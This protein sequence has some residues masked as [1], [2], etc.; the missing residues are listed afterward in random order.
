MLFDARIQTNNI[1]RVGDLVDDDYDEADMEI[2]LMNKVGY[3]FFSKN[4]YD[5]N[6][7]LAISLM[8]DHHNDQSKREE[9]PLEKEKKKPLLSFS[10][11]S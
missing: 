2:N 11:P 3:S 7:K 9:F 1:Y 6:I 10:P 8:D 5:F 4:F